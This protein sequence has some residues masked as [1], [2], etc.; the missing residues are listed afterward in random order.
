MKTWLKVSLAM[1]LLGVA[2]GTAL[3]LMGPRNATPAAAAK[4]EVALALTD[5][6]VVTLQRQNF[7]SSVEVSGSLPT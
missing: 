6:D 5:I 4:V 1:T 7:A 2:G 3:R